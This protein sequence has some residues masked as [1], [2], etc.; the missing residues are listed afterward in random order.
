MPRPSG[1]VMPMV[2]YIDMFTYTLVL[3]AVATLAI[4]IRK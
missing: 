2:S 4:K 1:E 3:V